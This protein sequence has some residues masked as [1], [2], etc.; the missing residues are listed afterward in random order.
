MSALPV[1]LSVPH[2]GLELP[3]EVASLCLLSAEQIAAESD[4]GAAEIYRPLADEVAAMVTTSVARVIVDLNRA[5]DDIRADGVVKTHTRWKAPIYRRALS[6]QE[7]EGLIARHYRPYHAELRRQATRARLGIDGHTM[8]A[9]GPP[10]GPDPGVE[11]PLVCLGHG[12]GSCPE[13]WLH[14]LGACLAHH[15]SA[16]VALNAPYAGG[17]ITRSRPGEIPWVQIELSRAEWLSHAEKT[18][19]IRR[20]LSDFCAELGL[21]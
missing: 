11:R 16:D 20:A 14:E 5:Q 19:A 13:R 18:A 9:I 8:E 4:G 2:A 6:A 3:P 7:I 10:V 15:L 21:R 17:F 12:R 1:L